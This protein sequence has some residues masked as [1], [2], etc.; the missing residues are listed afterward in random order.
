MGLRKLM[1]STCAIALSL[2][3][4]QYAVAS[5]AAKGITRPPRPAAKRAAVVK[6]QQLGLPGQPQGINADDF[7]DLGSDKDDTELQGGVTY[8]GDSQA[9]ESQGRTT[10]PLVTG[11]QSAAPRLADQQMNP[12]VIDKQFAA[13]RFVDQQ[14]NP[15]VTGQQFVGPPGGSQGYFQPQQVYGVPAPNYGYSYPPQPQNWVWQQAPRDSGPWT[16]LQGPTGEEDMRR[17]PQHYGP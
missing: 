15:L 7:R 4:T 3:I 6:P 17:Y 16:T 14:V 9:S 10:S 5:L 1:Y 13:P 11:Q 12:L 8:L 2:S